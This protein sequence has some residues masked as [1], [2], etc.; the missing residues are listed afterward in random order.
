MA[1]LGAVLCMALCFAPSALH[2]QGARPAIV[3]IRDAETESFIRAIVSPLAA[4]AG[5]DTRLIRV[6]LIRDRRI[7]AFVAT[8]NRMFFHT[9]LLLQGDGLA[10]FA[11]VVAHE[12]GH[13]SGGHL[14]R[15]PEELR[16]A[17]LRSAAAMLLGGLAGAV[18][19]SPDL[20]MGAIAGGQAM[21]M[22]EFFAFSRAQEQAADAAAIAYL[23][24]LGWTPRGLERLLQ[25]LLEQELLA[26]GRQDPYFQTHPL[27]RDRLDYVRDQIARSRYADTAMPA[28]LEARFQMVRAKLSGF[29]EGPA[30]VARRYPHSDTSP[31]ARYA[32]AIV[33]FRSGRVD[34][35]LRGLDSLIREA[36]GSPWLHELRG[37]VLFESGRIVESVAPYR[38]ASRLA[39]GEGLI[40]LNHGRALI[41]VGNEASLRA[42][43]V[44]LRAALDTE[45]ESGFAWRLIGTAQGRLGNQ[46]EA[47]LAMAEEAVLRGEYPDARFLAARAERALPP[48]PSRLRAADLRQSLR[49]DNLTPE[50]R[51]ME[52]E[53][54]RREPR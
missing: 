5:V 25:R 13:I 31:P 17:M 43:I 50:Q 16:N 23:D 47:D 1:L 53:M 41:E 40:R 15:L 46:G 27:S 8:G 11:G 20:A 48:G 49:R 21:A 51:R 38:E 22:G 52:D 12:V 10:E 4:A 2:A 34:E 42:A 6:T 26:V 54:R 29:I 28:A 18:A 14:A 33:A 9:G 35:A 3:T 24:R 44:E 36:P 19:G 39:P 7:N 45:R 37:Q 32:R 30:G